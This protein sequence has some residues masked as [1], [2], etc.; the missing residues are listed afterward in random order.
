MLLPILLGLCASSPDAQPGMGD[1]AA[2][3]DLM[4]S[5]VG[6]AVTVSLVHT[7][8]MIGSG[9]A[10]AWVVYR[11]LGLRALRG[12][13]L[14]LDFAWALGLIAAGVAGIATAAIR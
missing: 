9:L 10:A 6:T 1:H 13:W 14:D 3:M 2:V 11:Y 12:A 8:A 7:A 5:S 4:R